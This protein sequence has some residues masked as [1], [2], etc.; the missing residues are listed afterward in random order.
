M[1]TLLLCVVGV[2]VALAFSACAKKPTVCEA[3]IRGLLLNPETAEF[4]DVE[5]L[6]LS[7]FRDRLL[8]NHLR[9]VGGS[10]FT[11]PSSYNWAPDAYMT[12][13]RIDPQAPGQIYSVHR[14]KV[15]GRDGSRI[16][17]HFACADLKG[18][19]HCLMLDD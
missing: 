1:K 15:D 19:C 14:I 9:R 10:A 2:F 18:S 6:N 13:A 12:Q 8:T 11:S 3:S 7:A 4:F 16:T 17:T 5:E